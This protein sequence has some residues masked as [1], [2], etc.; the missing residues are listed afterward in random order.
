MVYGIPVVI[1]P[2][3]KLIVDQLSTWDLDTM[4]FNRKIPQH[5]SPFMKSY[6]WS[7]TVFMDSIVSGGIKKV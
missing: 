1:F 7:L 2:S 5:L 3:S 4:T 6:C